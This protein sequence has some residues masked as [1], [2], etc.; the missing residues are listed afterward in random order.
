METEGPLEV[1]NDAF[2][3]GPEA[4]QLVVDAEALGHVGDLESSPLGKDDVLDAERLDGVEIGLRGEG[5]TEDRLSS[6]WAAY[7]LLLTPDRFDRESSVGR[8]AS[9][10]LAVEDHRGSTDVEADPVSV[11][12]LF[13]VLTNDVGVVFEYRDAPLIGWHALV[14]E[15]AS[16]GLI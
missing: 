10:D 16:A 9:E 14:L 2:D 5:S 3:T 6:R 1:G 15:D 4:T 7:D 13:E 11:T 8:V 12:G